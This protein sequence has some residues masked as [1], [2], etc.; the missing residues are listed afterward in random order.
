MSKNYKNITPEAMEDVERTNKPKTNSIFNEKNYLNVRLKGDEESKTLRIRLLPIDSNSQTPFKKIYM[1]TIQLPESVD[2][3]RSWK[4][5]VCLNKTEDIDHET[6]GHK[7]PFCELNHSAYLEFQKASKEHN[8]IDSERWKKISTGARASEVCI[9]RCI[10]RGHEDDGPKFWKFTIRDDGKDPMHLINALYKTRRDES[11]EEA[12]LDN[13]GELPEDFEPK[14]ILDLYEGIDLKVT[15]SAVYDKEGK[16]TNKTSVAIVD[17]GRPRP[18]SEDEDKIDE[19][20]N[21]KKVWS[22]VFVA[23]PYEYLSIIID[24]KSPY[25]DK[26]QNKWVARNDNSDEDEAKKEEKEE[27]TREIN[28]KIKDAEKSYGKKDDDEDDYEVEEYDED[29]APENDLPF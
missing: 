1:H 6:L 13:G 20:V 28:K 27:K 11:I 9:V 26:T 21:D 2:S 4:S 15:I 5:F 25:F 14:N 17:Y 19:W 23:K 18:V 22:D 24:G 16:R 10:E 7:C 12:K 3:K 8:E 29:D